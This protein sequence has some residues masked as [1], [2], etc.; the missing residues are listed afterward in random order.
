MK[1]MH[2]QSFLG[3]SVSVRSPFERDFKVNLYVQVICSEIYTNLLEWHNP[4][5]VSLWIKEV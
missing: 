1:N 5:S 3:V 4:L 2:R